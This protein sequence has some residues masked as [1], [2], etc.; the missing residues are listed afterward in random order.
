MSEGLASAVEKA[1]HDLAEPSLGSKP[2]SCHRSTRFWR[3]AN[4]SRKSW[5]TRHPAKIQVVLG[6]AKPERVVEAGAGSSVSLTRE[7]WYRLFRAA[8]HTLP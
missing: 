5:I 4:R 3:S 8:G 2:I 6:T 1:E 7:K